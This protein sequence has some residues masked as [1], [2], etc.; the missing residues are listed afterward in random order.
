MS[1]RDVWAD[2]TTIESGTGWVPNGATYRIDDDHLGPGS[3]C[4]D[5]GDNASLPADVL[6][7]DGD[8]DTTEMLPV[9]WDGESRRVDDP[10][11][12]D[13]GLGDPPLVDFG[14][15]EFVPRPAEDFD[16]DGD[17]DAADLAHLASCALGP[18][19]RQTKPACINADLDGDGDVD[20]TDFAHFQ[21]SIIETD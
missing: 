1:P 5:A 21:R 7:L 11:V 17:V 18:T 4:I 10:L 13:T 16:L 15:Y 6:D 2:W 8:G 19:V 9:D 3:P 14:P 12:P 20:Q